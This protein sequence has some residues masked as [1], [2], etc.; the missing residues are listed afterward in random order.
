MCVLCYA[1][2]RERRRLKRITH[3]A[4]R[5]CRSTK[6]ADLHEFHGVGVNAASVEDGYSVTDLR[7]MHTIF[8]VRVRIC[9]T[10]AKIGD[11]VKNTDLYENNMDDTV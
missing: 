9:L 2:Y 10:A 1:I 6:P 3:S 5:A 11:T 4:R 7:Q 8:C